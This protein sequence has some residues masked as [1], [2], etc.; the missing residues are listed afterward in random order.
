MCEVKSC[1]GIGPIE[2]IIAKKYNNVNSLTG[3][4]GAYSKQKRLILSL[5]HV[6]IKNA[7]GTEKNS[8]H[9]SRAHF[10]TLNR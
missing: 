1:F 8:L 10:F 9:P 5:V 6:P 7:A 2:Y 4:K 3:V